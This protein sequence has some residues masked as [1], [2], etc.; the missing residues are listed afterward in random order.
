MRVRRKPEEPAIFRI[1]R[2]HV[3]RVHRLI[4]RKRKKYYH[5]CRK[6]DGFD[7]PLDLPQKKLSYKERD[8]KAYKIRMALR[9]I[10]SLEKKYNPH[11]RNYFKYNLTSGKY[12]DMLDKV[13][14]FLEESRQN[15]SN[16]LEHLLMDY[17]EMIYK[18]FGHYNKTPFL[19]QLGSSN[20]NKV[21]WDDFVIRFKRKNKDSYYK[22]GVDYSKVKEKAKQLAQ[23]HKQIRNG[24]KPISD[25]TTAE[26]KEV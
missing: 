13:V 18:N 23:K 24:E 14:K 15:Y 10:N 11:P 16:P 3:L 19:Q 26:I 2:S 5:R 12:Y 25:S 7:L 8:T 21:K 1:Q 4:H 9:V 20:T 6:K 17:F 22:R